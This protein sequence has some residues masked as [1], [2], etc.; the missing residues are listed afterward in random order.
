MQYAKQALKIGYE[1]EVD[2]VKIPV[3]NVGIQ[4]SGWMRCDAKE[5]NA[6]DNAMDVI[7]KTL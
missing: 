7:G 3:E 4:A 6:M 5:N 1:L 2:E